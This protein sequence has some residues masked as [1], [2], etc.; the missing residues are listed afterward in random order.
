MTYVKDFFQ[1]VLAQDHCLLFIIKR[2]IIQNLRWKLSK[3][4]VELSWPNGMIIQ[5][6]AVNIM[7]KDWQ[8]AR[9]ISCWDSYLD[10]DNQYLKL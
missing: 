4:T 3:E 2:K 5:G 10:Y 1:G 7:L 9:V 6:I 8:E